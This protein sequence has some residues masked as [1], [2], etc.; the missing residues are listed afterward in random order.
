[1]KNSVSS[2]AVAVL[3]ALGAPLAP[4]SGLAAQQDARLALAVPMEL[5][6]T[7]LERPS[8]LTVEG[9]SLAGALTTL[10]L[11]SGVSLAFSPWALPV[12]RQVTC[13]CAE[14]SVA[15]TLDILLEGTGLRYGAVADQ[16][17][18]EPAPARTVMVAPPTRGQTA[19]YQ[20][21][22]LPVPRSEVARRTG[23]VTGIIRDRAGMSPLS[24]AQVHIP[25]TGVGT[26]TGANGRYLL[27]QV[28]AGTHTLRVE[29]LGYSP[30]QVEIQVV[31]GET[32]EVN[33]QLQQQA[34]DLDEIIVTGTPGGTQRRAIGNVV[35]RIDASRLVESTPSVN[36]E[37]LL[38]GRTPGVTVRPAPGMVGTGTAIHIRGVSS[39]S[40]GNTPLIYVDGVRIDNNSS[41]GPPLRQGRQVSR[42]NDINPED[43]ESIEIIK[44]PAAATLYGTEASN[45]VIQIITKRGATGA[46]VLD[47]TIRQGATWMPDPAGRISPVYSYN[48]TTG[49]TDSVNLYQREADAGRPI[50]QTGHLQS[51]TASIRG[52][53]DAVRYYLSA[54]VDDHE[55]IVDYNWHEKFSTR[56]NVTVVPGERWN[57]DANLGFVRSNTRFAQAA[58]GFGIWDMLVWG[59]PTRLETPTR[60][61]QYASPET[62]G[63]ID[64][65]SVYNRFTGG[66]Q[67]SHDVT[68]WLT[69]RLT[70]GLDAGFDESSQLFPR[71][72]PGQVNFFGAR[73]SGQKLVENSSTLYTTLD[74]GASATFQ[75]TPTVNS[76]TSVG[77]Q[78]YHRQTSSSGAQGNEFPAPSVTTVSGA[79]TS[80]GQE[81]FIENKTLGTYIQQQFGWRDRVFVTGAVR[82]DD[83]SA[84]GADF[85][86]AIYPKFSAT[87]VVSEEDFWSL[88]AV[89]QLRL[90]TAWGQAG[91]QP[92]VFDAIRL[93]NP[94]TGPGDQPVLLPGSFG[95]PQLEP[96]VGEEIELGFDA[97]LFEDR[98]SL[99]FT[100]FNKT[101]KNAIANARV[102]PSLGFPGNQI[103][104]LGEVK[105]WGAE[106]T[107]GADLLRRGSFGWD[108]A[109]NFGTHKNEVTDLGGLAPI[110]HGTD[111]QHRVGYPI[112]SIFAQ[113]MVG[114]EL[115]AQ[116]RLINAMCDG[117]PENNNQPMP[118]ADAPEVYFGVPDPT[119]SGSVTSGVNL[120]GL[121]LS[122]LVDFR[123][124]HTYISGDINAGH[125]TFNNT[126]AVNPVTDP[127]LQGYRTVVSRTGAGVFDAGFAKLRE[128]SASYNL[129]S[130]WVGLV[131][132]SRASLNLSWRNVADLWRA[133]DEIWGTKI[134]D[135]ETINPGDSRSA[136][137]QTTLPPTSQFMGSLRFTF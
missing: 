86:A 29:R 121:R 123:G 15:E 66:L 20:P 99:G 42:F 31:S 44:G 116:R 9:E 50:F 135:S 97:G 133:Q 59:S 7:Q 137:F 25:G 43:I 119:W 112:S 80:L 68:G 67:L 88:G 4:H 136:R 46:A 26:L 120:G 45:G 113:R 63:L 70:L 40:L 134:F 131:G 5:S 30:V 115:D 36:T 60:G 107:L 10:G 87:W 57:I 75:L 108:V 90:R 27:T 118:C 41:A 132:A 48:P 98:I 16:L 53:T 18:I 64:S 89:N 104:N 74:W 2:A 35:E 52:G 105:S 22:L 101:T 39:L 21:M 28:P 129:P 23:T 76:Q 103:V 12:E 13:H 96:E 92:D 78:Y 117:G 100:W 24:A 114:G 58:V 54:D 81:D 91:Q 79:A 111:Q 1:M 62:A 102:R 72:P 128:L 95:N 125:T 56:A 106:V 73:G 109:V 69:Q 94:S 85:D 84:F 83:N 71:I 14:L 3:L 55:G 110:R 33:L 127:L 11:S 51:Y 124:G 6:R 49:V 8:G 65:R 93:Y 34:L 122:A 17:V 32:L 130:D 47:F 82:A 61:F 38:G 37:Q 19:R 77:I 126:R